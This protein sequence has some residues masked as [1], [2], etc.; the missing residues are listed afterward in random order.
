MSL[1]ADWRLG[2]DIDALAPERTVVWLGY[3]AL[4][5]H[6]DADR[7]IPVSH[8]ACVA[9]AGPPGTGLWR[10]HSARHVEAFES[11]SDEYVERVAE[12]LDARL[13]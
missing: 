10:V 5:I 1:L 9:E 7:R 6:G 12:Y 2:I 3:P 11:N 8:G 4:V 13:R